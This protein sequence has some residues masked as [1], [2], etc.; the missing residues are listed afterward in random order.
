VARLQGK[1]AVDDLFARLAG[2]L[3]DRVGGPMSFRL[4]C[5][6]AMAGILAV[7]DGM[8][9]GRAGRPAYGWAILTDSASRRERLREGWRAVAR[10]FVL[11]VV[12]DTIYQL[13]ELRWFY[14]LETMIVALTL[15]FVPYV[16][17]RGPVGRLTSA[18]KR[19]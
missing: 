2:N 15:A 6:P 1:A 3:H 17:I 8:R 7:R 11:A 18:L 4:L 9:D 10:I 14:P 5:Q 13:I 12:V 16:L 19:G